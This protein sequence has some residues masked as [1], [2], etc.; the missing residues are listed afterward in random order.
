MQT[1]ANADL[2]RGR[3]RRID[4]QL[5]SHMDFL[6]R[7]SPSSSIGQTGE[8]KSLLFPSLP[9]FLIAWDRHPTV[10]NTRTRFLLS[11]PPFLQRRCII[12]QFA[13]G[14]RRKRKG[15][16]K[17]EPLRKRKDSESLGRGIIFRS[18]SYP[19]FGC[20]QKLSCAMMSS[21]V[22]AGIHTSL[23]FS[24]LSVYICAPLP[25][26]GRSR[27]RLTLIFLHP[28]YSGKN[29]RMA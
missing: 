13:C 24:L 27:D 5:F 9:C 20:V 14:R 11:F 19:M 15:K 1:V 16:G 21:W 2:L 6:R 28:F 18:S 22:G 3:R 25:L 4:V 17:V 10:K 7:F 29:A 26:L 8:K 23:C 12:V